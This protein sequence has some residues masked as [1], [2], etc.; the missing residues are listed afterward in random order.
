MKPSI[1]TSLIVLAQEL[2]ERISA[3]LE[4][5][6]EK[7]RLG[8]WAGMLFIASMKIDDL[9][10]GLF[11]ENKEI[12]SFLLK[13]ESE[14]TEDLAKKIKDIELSKPTDIKISSL[15]EFNQKLKILLIETHSELEEKNQSSALK[16]IWNVLRSIHQ[17]R[18]VNHLLQAIN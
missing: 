7:S 1:N 13:Y 3:L 17:N 4:D 18:K 11:N 16:D 15:D 8:A 2:N 6:Y 9:A 10:D 12:L 14:L 5:E